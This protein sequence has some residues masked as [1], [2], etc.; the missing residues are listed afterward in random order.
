MENVKKIIGENITELRKKFNYTQQDLA[1]LLV[2]SDKSISKWERGESTPDIEVLLKIAELF[3]VDINFLLTPLTDEERVKRQKMENKRNSYKIFV[4]LLSCLTVWFA[5]VFLFVTF[6]VIEGTYDWIVYLWAVPCTFIVLLVFNCIWGK[7][8]WLFS[9]LTCL[10]WTF[11]A[12]F[13]VHI[14]VYIHFNIWHVYLLGIPLQLALVLWYL[15]L[16]SKK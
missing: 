3:K 11:F 1:N 7:A 10:L 2:Y 14:L 16:R 4:S 5:A 13:H 9:I 6:K 8:K 15:L 12:S